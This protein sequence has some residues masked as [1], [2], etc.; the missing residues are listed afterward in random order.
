M[1]AQTGL[2]LTR[3]AR[4]YRR[5]LSSQA[6]RVHEPAIHATRS[7]APSI[8]RAS[9]LE[10]REL[11]I[12]LPALSAQERNAIVLALYHPR[13]F[14]LLAQSV[15]SP[16][17]VAHPL[18]DHPDATEPRD[19]PPL[20]GTLAVAER[21]GVFRLH[22]KEWVDD[23]SHEEGGYWTAIPWLGD[24]L[25]CLMDARGPYCVNWNVKQ[26]VGDHARPHDSQPRRKYSPRALAHAAARLD[27]EVGY[28]ADASIRTEL[29]A[30]ESM[31]KGALESLGHLFRWNL[32]PVPMSNAAR[33]MLENQYRV[34]MRDGIPPIVT[35]SLARKHSGYSLEVC[36]RVLY[37]CIWRRDLR[38]DLFKPVLVD[39]PLRP[40]KRDVL[41]EYADW[42]RR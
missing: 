42:F 29:I 16:V 15:L 18:H 10:S 2:R 40:E 4:I 28:Y 32:Q 11:G 27:V 41:I 6:N 14:Q 35:M 17:P 3:V 22:P 1:A 36:K 39:R 7:E 19:F 26:H 30:G 37:Q 25:P 13:L 33:K 8:S 9:T 20:K 38:V 23:D 34:G 12:V 31:D 24:L 5:L 21:F